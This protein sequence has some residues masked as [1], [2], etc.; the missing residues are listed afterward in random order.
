MANFP[1][2]VKEMRDRFGLSQS[3]LANRIDVKAQTVSLWERGL[4]F[5]SPPMLQKLS[6]Y[7]NVQIAFL[8]GESDDDSP[9]E[10]ILDM[11]RKLEIEADIS[12]LSMMF[13]RLSRL[14]S[15]M[16]QVIEGAI[17]AAYRYDRDNDNLNYPGIYD[18]TIRS[19]FDC[20]RGEE[21]IKNLDYAEEPEPWTGEIV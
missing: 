12:E 13:T 6:D 16:R 3:Q 4:R 14:S 2:R 20:M 17:T 8:T 15:G 5:P 10:D 9:R 7:F 19:T 18:I 11:T 21:P 1:S